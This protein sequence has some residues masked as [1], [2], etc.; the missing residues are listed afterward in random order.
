MSS[1]QL[2]TCFL[3]KIL[4]RSQSRK[5][6][7]ENNGSVISMMDLNYNVRILKATKGNKIVAFSIGG[8]TICCPDAVYI[9]AYIRKLS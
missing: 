3:Q 6:R 5:F 9:S 2:V 7:T 4:N 1:S 8:R